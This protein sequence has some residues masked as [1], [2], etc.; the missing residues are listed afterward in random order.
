MHLDSVP[1]D[2][3]PRIGDFFVTIPLRVLENK[4]KGMPL[5]I[6]T[7]CVAIG[8]PIHAESGNSMS[9]DFPVVWICNVFSFWRFDLNFITVLHVDSAVGVTVRFTISPGAHHD[10]FNMALITGIFFLGHQVVGTPTLA[11]A[12]HQGLT[13]AIWVIHDLP[14]DIHLLLG[15]HFPIFSNG[16]HGAV[17]ENFSPL[18]GFQSNVLAL[19]IAALFLGFLSGLKR[20]DPCQKGKV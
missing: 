1:P 2:R 19:L 12:C 15:P 16:F 10:E 13:L 17:K 6:G 5:T 3:G 4:M 11:P 18:R 9:A 8:N 20:S 7:P 14:S